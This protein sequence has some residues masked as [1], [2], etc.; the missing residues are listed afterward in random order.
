MRWS[1]RPKLG[2]MCDSVD[3]IKAKQMKQK[4]K[5]M[6]RSPQFWTCKPRKLQY[7]YIA[8]RELAHS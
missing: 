4:I 8:S 6:G 1:R 5:L 3:L 7:P 2:N